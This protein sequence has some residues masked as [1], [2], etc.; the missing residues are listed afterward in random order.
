MENKGKFKA[1]S[2]LKRE[3]RVS[4]REEAVLIEEDG[5]ALDVVITDISREGFRLE[6]R[7]ELE[8]GAEVWLRV[9]KLEPVRAVIR[10][11]RGTE[12]GGVFLE[13]VAL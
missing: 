1:G 3:P 7:A 12:A 10:W 9:A 2:Y 11:T 4:V 13:P 8:V 6:S 5:C